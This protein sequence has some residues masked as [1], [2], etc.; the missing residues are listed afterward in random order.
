MLLG[1]AL[2]FVIVNG[3]VLLLAGLAKLMPVILFAL[4][5]LMFSVITFAIMIAV[6]VAIAYGLIKLLIAI[7]E[8]LR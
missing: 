3:G 2:F 5:Y 7:F 4:L 6:V 8:K 1:V